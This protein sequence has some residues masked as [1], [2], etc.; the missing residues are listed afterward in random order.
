MKRLVWDE[1]DSF[2]DLMPSCTFGTMWLGPQTLQIR[3]KSDEQAAKIMKCSVEEMEA[4]RERF[5]ASWKP[6]QETP[7]EA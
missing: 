1:R 7:V 3:A 4:A 5:L 6:N 2:V